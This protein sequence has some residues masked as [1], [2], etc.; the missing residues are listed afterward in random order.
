[1]GTADRDPPRW[2]R[3]FRLGIRQKVLLILLSTLLVTLSASGWLTLRAH[4]KD[5]V[6]ETSRRG[7]ELTH[8]VANNL[9]YRVVANDYHTIELQLKE[10]VTHEDIVYAR[11][12][13]AKGN[14]MAEVGEARKN[15]RG[16]DVPRG[17]PSEKSRETA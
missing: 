10:L 3:I 11:V 6:D 16:L 8:I 7:A 15:D 13:S 5:I 4:Q 1:M 9:A 12:L 14:I 17:H 2:R